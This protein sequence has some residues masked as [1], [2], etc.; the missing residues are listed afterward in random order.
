MKEQDSSGI[1]II[2]MSGRFPG[3]ANIGEFWHNLLGG[4]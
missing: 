1:A 4:V 3:A 2:G